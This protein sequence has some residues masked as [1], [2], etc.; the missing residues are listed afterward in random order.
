MNPTPTL[1]MQPQLLD[2]NLHRGKRLLP[3]KDWSVAARM[4][5]VP[6]ASSE[7]PE[8]CKEYLIGFVAAP[9]A[10]GQPAT[11]ATVA[12]VVVLGLRDQENLFVATDGSWDARYQPAFLRRYP[13]GYAATGENQRSVIVDTA[14]PGFNEAE[15]ELLLQDD[16]QPSPW[17]AQQ[18]KFLDA[19]EVELQRTRVLCHV[20]VQHQLLKSVN[21]DVTLPGGQK[22]TVAQI[23]VVDETKLRALP[24]STLAELLRN[25][26]IGLMHAH[27]ISTSNAVRLTERLSRRQAAARA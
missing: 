16:G 27:L 6:V 25:G 4:T 5:A 15:G 8:L 13:L 11:H 1:Y 2:R 10:A 17:L 20:L 18:M 7:F 23:Q 21:L 22:Q 12:P 14:W 3:V 26:A 9:A 24:E 19:F